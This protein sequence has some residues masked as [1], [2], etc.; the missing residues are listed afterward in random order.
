[1]EI[2]AKTRTEQILI[3]MNIL[4]WVAFVGF[5]IEAGAIAYSYF[6]SILW[7]D[8]AKDLYRGLDLSR[9]MQF[10]FWQY[11]LSVSYRVAIKIMHSYAFFLAIKCL[12]NVKLE[13]P[14]R[15]DVAF[16]IERISYVLLSTWVVA[17]V[18]NLHT[19]WLSTRIKEF[20]PTMISG[21]FIF[22]AGLL[23]VVAQIF[24]RGVEIQSENEL[25]V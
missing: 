17:M 22:A 20:V 3:V 1:M 25:T 2:K 19:Y 9:L 21:E 6:V 16:L 10:N 7:D 13:N 15:G 8:S 18:H 23:F 12:S 11:T 4:A 5:A 24:K 14:F